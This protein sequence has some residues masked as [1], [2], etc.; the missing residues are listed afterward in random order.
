VLPL[1]PPGP[2][3]EPPPSPVPYVFDASEFEMVRNEILNMI[4]SI[5][6]PIEL[7]KISREDLAR[8]ILNYKRYESGELNVKGADLVDYLNRLSKSINDNHFPLPSETKIKLEERIDQYS[9]FRNIKNYFLS[10]QSLPTSSHK[11]T[12]NNLRR[13]KN[14]RRSTR[15]RRS[16]RRMH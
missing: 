5:V 7:P 16:T 4:S 8:I 9:L 1:L 14:Y 2:S 13:R 11:I 12:P 3:R 15:K 6:S 10:E